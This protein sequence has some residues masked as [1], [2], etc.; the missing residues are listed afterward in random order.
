MRMVV[1]GF[2][3]G[4]VHVDGGI[5]TYAITWLPGG[6]QFRLITVGPHVAP[7]SR[8]LLVKLMRFGEHNKCHVVVEYMHSRCLALLAELGFGEVE[9]IG[10]WWPPDVPLM[11][12]KLP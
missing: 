10:Y 1:D 7:V 12:H 4:Y 5:I 3:A 8:N 11:D 6:A 9:G 2:E